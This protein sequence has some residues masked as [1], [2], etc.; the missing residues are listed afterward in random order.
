[1]SW[2][3]NCKGPCVILYLCSCDR[4]SEVTLPMLEDIFQEDR[5][6]FSFKMIDLKSQE[7]PM[8]VQD[9]PTIDMCGMRVTGIPDE[10]IVRNEL[11]KIVLS[12][13]SVTT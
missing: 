13:E 3:C 5:F 9:S 1:M 2:H 12:K 4:W 6:G 7:S 8:D 11:F 10:G